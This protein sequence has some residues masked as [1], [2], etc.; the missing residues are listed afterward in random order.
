M[1]NLKPAKP[2][3][4]ALA[5]F[6][7]LV[8]LYIVYAVIRL[9]FAGNSAN[10]LVNTL[11]QLKGID[12]SKPAFTKIDAS[13]SDAIEDLSTIKSAANDPLFSPIALMPWIGQD[14]AA[15]KTLSI[16]ALDLA[17]SLRPC[18]LELAKLEADNPGKSTKEQIGQIS[19][20]VSKHF[21]SITT[22]VGHASSSVATINASGLHFGLSEKIVSL[23][24]TLAAAKSQITE[25]KP[26]LSVVSQVLTAQKPTNWF[27]ATQNLAEARGAGGILG[28]YAVIRATGSKIKLIGTGSDVEL[29]ASGPVN[30]KALP[31]DL[32]TIWNADPTDWR[33]INTSI[34]VPYF[35]K[36]IVQNFDGKAKVSGV[37]FLGQGIV[38]NLVGAL[39]SVTYKGDT[40]D[41]SNATT[42]LAQTVYLKHPDQASKN[43]WVKGFMQ[44]V[45]SKLAEG[46]VNLPSFLKALQQNPTNDRLMAWSSDPKVE[47]SF[48]NAGVSGAV[49][50]NFG[51]TSYFSFNN[52]GG[53]KLD[54]YLHANA[55]YALGKCGD[56][57][58][59]G[60]YARLA[61]VQIN[62]QNNSPKKILS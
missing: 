51:S 35:A 15:V 47:K 49:D 44:L 22:S 24:I 48:D 42:F 60:Y 50:P 25:L 56:A 26:Y 58:D 12:S 31:P 8:G 2:A 9:A 36:Q 21:D 4:A 55:S 43:A 5:G 41:A 30:P 1:K 14:F 29:L 54:A 32:Q 59:D 16:P 3:K 19:A 23:Q 27:I 18:T 34:H 6:G 57:T 33:D 28:S 38:S 52:A 13:L 17:S 7:I 45:F 37:I 62:L 40:I 53:N 39:G 20:I 11:Q 10:D 61:S 46:N